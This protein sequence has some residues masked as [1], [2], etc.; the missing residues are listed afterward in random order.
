MPNEMKPSITAMPIIS[1]Y[2]R[3]LML[4]RRRSS[5]RVSSLPIIAPVNLPTSRR[6]EWRITVWCVPN[7]VNQMPHATMVPNSQNSE[8][9]LMRLYCWI[10]SCRNANTNSDAAN[11]TQRSMHKMNLVLT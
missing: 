9:S 3:M 7:A 4:K 2:G 6:V 8:K 1:L 11:D 5:V 10:N